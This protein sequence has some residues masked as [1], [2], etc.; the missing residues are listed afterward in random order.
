VSGGLALDRGTLWVAWYEKTAHVAPFDWNGRSVA[1]GFSFCDARIGRASVRDLALD[2]DRNLWI[3]DEA[4]SRLRRF[5][6]FGQELGGL[7][8]PLDEPLLDEPRAEAE[9]DAPSKVRRPTAVV[10]SGDSD[11][12]ELLV[13][14]GGARRHA[15]QL[16]TGEGQLI[17]TLRSLGD[18]H[19]R[20]QGISGL[21]RRERLIAI[22]EEHADRIQIFRDLDFHYSIVLPADFRPT[23][24]KF[25]SGDRLLI[26][27]APGVFIYTIASR[28][29]HQLAPKT[30][31]FDNPLAL[32]VEERSTD[33][34]SRLAVLDRLA[35]RIQ[36]LN[37]QGRLYGTFT[38]QTP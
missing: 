19:A 36:V 16:F 12:L 7:G 34:K 23:D 25:L 6:V 35:T 20:F 32:A 8:L 38:P 33:R 18:P 9:N 11:G 30:D 10:A 4:S 15:L 5:S 22:C 3:A 1:R 26:S 27:G 13:G 2:D 21:C 31:P 37:L 24:L 28:D 29:L 17:S 14:C